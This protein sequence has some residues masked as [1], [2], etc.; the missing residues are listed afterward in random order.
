MSDIRVEI[1]MDF[2]KTFS[3]T[4]EG[5]EGE[6]LSGTIDIMAHNLGRMGQF[7]S[8]TVE[9][10]TKHILNKDRI[11]YVEVSQEAVE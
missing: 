2:G 10:G 3:Y 4:T 9:D 11:A 1:H 6:N 7:I 8:V 5:R